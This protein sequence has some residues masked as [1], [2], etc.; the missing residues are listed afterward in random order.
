[1]KDTKLGIL[2]VQKTILS[3]IETDI[4]A[5]IQSIQSKDAQEGISASVQVRRPVFTPK[6]K[7]KI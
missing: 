2:N 7:T 1:M 5:T 4:Q 6:I 3:L